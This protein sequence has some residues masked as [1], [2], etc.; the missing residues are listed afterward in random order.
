MVRTNRGG[1]TAVAAVVAGEARPL[2]RRRQTC[3]ASRR[4]AA[5][6]VVAPT[7]VSYKLCA[8]VGVARVAAVAVAVGVAPADPRLLVG[9]D[10]QKVTLVR[11]SGRKPVGRRRVAEVARSRAVVGLAAAAKP[12]PPAARRLTCAG[13]SAVARPVSEPAF[14]RIRVRVAAYA[15]RTPAPARVVERG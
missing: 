14:A 9:G 8:P 7:A 3:V 11:G 15:R 2:A 10:P 13:V 5:D 6:A 4:D 12:R 1:L